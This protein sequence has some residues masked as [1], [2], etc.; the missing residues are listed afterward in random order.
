MGMNK[1]DIYSFV[2]TAHCLLLAFLGS[3][4]STLDIV[5]GMGLY[6]PPSHFH[7]GGR[8]RRC[9]G[10]QGSFSFPPRKIKHSNSND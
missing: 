1:T 5:M 9:R 10:T 4:F 8:K 7:N 2:D 6:P 3:T